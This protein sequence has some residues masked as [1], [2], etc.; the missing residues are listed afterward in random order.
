MGFCQRFSFS[1]GE[2]WQLA[3]CVSCTCRVGHVLCRAV[4]CPAIA[5]N[6]PVMHPDDQCCP[7]SIFIDF[8]DSFISLSYSVDQDDQFIYAPEKESLYLDLQPFENDL[9]LPC[10][11]NTTTEVSGSSTVCTDNYGTA[12]MAGA[13]WRTDDCTSC[14]C[15]ADGKV[16]CYRQQC[17]AD[18]NCHGKPLTV[19]GRCCPVC[20]GE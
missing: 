9:T 12:H 17:D 6:N 5:C 3:P 20:E 19:K 4:D 2:T 1:D 14:E 10:P 8:L 13:S 18:A 16:M 15:S 11:S 7:R